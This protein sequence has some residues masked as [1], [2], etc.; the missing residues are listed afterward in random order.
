[1]TQTAESILRSR[2]MRHLEVTTAFAVVIHAIVFLAWPP[3]L[4]SPYEI[5]EKRLEVLNLPEAIEIP[6]PPAEVERPELAQEAIISDDVSDDATIAPT[7]YNPFAPP[8]IPSRPEPEAFYAFDSPP[9]VL[10]SVEPEYPERAREAEAEGDVLVEVTI[11]EN[12]RVISARVI[13]SDT[14]AALEE[15]ALDAAYEYLFKPA[16]QADVPVKCRVV[17]PFSFTLRD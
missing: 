2:Y 3:Y 1:M 12:G 16:R 17:I 8:V 10:R 7:E 5:E 15:A 6:P 11:D 4:P 9:E 14:I 13:A